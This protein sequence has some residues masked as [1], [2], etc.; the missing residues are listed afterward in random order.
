MANKDEDNLQ[1]LYMPSMIPLESERY[2]SDIAYRK[3]GLFIHRMKNN[4][5]KER[6][7]TEVLM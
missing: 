2:S 7:I 4:D 6:D 3:E 1:K 5:G